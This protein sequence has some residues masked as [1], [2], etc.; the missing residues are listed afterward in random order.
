MVWVLVLS[1]RLFDDAESDTLHISK[2]TIISESVKV[3]KVKSDYVFKK[4]VVRFQFL[5]Y[6]LRCAIKKYFES[7]KV[8]TELDAV[9]LLCTNHIDKYVI[10]ERNKF[11]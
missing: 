3:T 1:W 2:A 6:L 4:E 5:E 8:E 7:G 9:K 10:D 11:D